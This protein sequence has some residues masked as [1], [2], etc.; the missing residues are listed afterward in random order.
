MLYYENNKLLSRGEQRL[1][2]V[3]RRFIDKQG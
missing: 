3:V 1:S 2:I